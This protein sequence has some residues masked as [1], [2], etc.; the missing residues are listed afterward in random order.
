[1]QFNPNVHLAQVLKDMNLGNGPQ[2]KGQKHIYPLQPQIKKQMIKS[3]NEYINDQIKLCKK[4]RVEFLP[5]SSL[6]KVGIAINIRDGILPLNGLRHPIEGETN[7][8]YL[9]AGEEFSYSEDFFLPL[10]VEH[11]VDWCPKVI[12][13]LAL[14]PGWRFLTDGQFDDVWFDENLLN[15]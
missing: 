15:I 13:F 12:K 5:P 3:Y 10:H 8:W 6:T 7:G 4:Y 1:M 14:P 11:L 2:S 9:W